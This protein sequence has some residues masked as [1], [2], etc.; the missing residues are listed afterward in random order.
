M[1][2]LTALF[3]RCLSEGRVPENWKNAS[4]VI[5]YK[6]SDKKGIKNYRPISLIPVIYKIFSQILTRKMIS[7]LDLQQT[8]EQAGFR[9]GFS[10]TDHIRA[11]SQLMEKPMGTTFHFASPVWTTRRLSTPSSSTRCSELWITKEWTRPTSTCCK[12][13]TKEPHL[14]LDCTN[15][16]TRSN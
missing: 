3:N 13:S 14:L 1:K 8:R 12:I 4:V 11:V 7:T 16:A 6:K 15:P 10:T 9:N 5:L 2:I